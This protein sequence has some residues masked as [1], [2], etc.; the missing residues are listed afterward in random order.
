M[1]VG[2]KRKSEDNFEN[3]EDENDTT[4][5]RVNTVMAKKLNKVSQVIF[6]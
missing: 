2:P 5:V 4:R 3:F 1:V 6:K